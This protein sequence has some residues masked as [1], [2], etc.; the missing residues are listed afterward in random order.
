MLNLSKSHCRHEDNI[1]V[2]GEKN[3]VTM[4][5]GLLRGKGVCQHSTG[6]ELYIKAREKGYLQALKNKVLRRRMGNRT[7]RNC[8]H[9]VNKSLE[10]V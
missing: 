10:V 6:I 1:T 9:S 4:P 7:D 5:A 3:L 2:R 8:F